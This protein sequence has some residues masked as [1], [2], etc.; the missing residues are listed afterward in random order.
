MYIIEPKKENLFVSSSL[1]MRNSKK[2]GRNQAKEKHTHTHKMNFLASID[3]YCYASKTLFSFFSS[4]TSYGLVGDD[5]G[6]M[7]N[8]MECKQIGD[9]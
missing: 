5:N 3:R 4:T 2:K 9:K 6:D 8:S 1:V 7:I